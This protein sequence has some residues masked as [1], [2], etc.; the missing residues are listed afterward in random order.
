MRIH[1][2]LAVVGVLALTSGVLSLHGQ[3]SPPAF[4]VASIKPSPSNTAGP[5]NSRIW[6]G[7]R[8]TAT[9]MTVK[10]LI[11][12]AYRFDITQSQLSGGPAWIDSER[13]DI[14]ARATPDAIVPGQIDLER[15]HIMGRMMQALLADRLGLH[16][17]R[18]TN[19]APVY[20]LVIAR[21][22]SKM[23]G[24]SDGV[25]CSALVP[26]GL[27][28]C[29]VFTR[30]GNRG[31][32]GERV[33]MS[34]ITMAFRILLGQPVVD[35]T[36]LMGLFNVAVNWAPD[37]LRSAPRDDAI[38]AAGDPNAPTMFT[39]VE[40]QLGLRLESRRAPVEFLVIER[41]EKPSEN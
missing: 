33:D 39:A 18:E 4:E 15:A 13:F 10:A 27:P 6:P 3:S 7:G 23:K 11:L 26:G 9:N 21:G 41:V 20:A 37:A 28:P 32:H 12:L 1:H 34:D 30:M 19:E 40:E 29:H 36:G 38:E 16:L 8:F 22:G 5:P 2:S 14:D 35:K 24:S 17:R 25:D 31:I